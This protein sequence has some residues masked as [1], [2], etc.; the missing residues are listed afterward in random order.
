MLAALL[1]ARERVR[2]VRWS[3]ARPLPALALGAALPWILHAV[4]MYERNR[5]DRYEW[6]GDIS[7]GTDHYAMQG[8]LAVALVGLSLLAA[9]WPRGRRHPGLGVGVVAGYLGLVSVTHPTHDA[10]LGTV[11]SALA[12]AWGLAVAGLSLVGPTAAPAPP[13]GRRDPGSPA[14][15]RPCAT[16]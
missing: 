1:P 6:Y 12:I 4:G 14:T 13:R 7:M 8:A 11:R 5:A 15:T 9:C 3:V 16:P 10:A 2:P